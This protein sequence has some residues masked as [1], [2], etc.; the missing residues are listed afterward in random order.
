VKLSL[1]LSGSPVGFIPFSLIGVCS[2]Y[3]LAR[4]L[5]GVRRC[6]S[7]TFGAYTEHSSH[8]L[9]NHRRCRGGSPWLAGV[10]TFWLWL[11]S[12]WCRH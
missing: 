11:R 8:G 12:E 1:F 7:C 6:L 9:A 4:Y 3:L 10:Y 5:Y 2:G